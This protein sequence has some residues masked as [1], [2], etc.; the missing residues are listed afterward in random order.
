MNTETFKDNT[1]VLN[2]KTGRVYRVFN[3]SCDADRGICICRIEKDGKQWGPIRNLKYSELEV[4][5]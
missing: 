1:R 4:V 2:K 5:A 3:G